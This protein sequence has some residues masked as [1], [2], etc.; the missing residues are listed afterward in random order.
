[1][2]QVNPE[3]LY[4]LLGG[5]LCLFGFAL[6]WGGLRVVGMFMGGS[7]AAIMTIIIAY[8][9]HMERMLALAV[10][11]LATLG[12]M[13]VGWRLLKGA[14][15]FLVF[16]IGAGLG[17]LIVKTIL[18]PYYGGL[19]EV[20]WVPLAAIVIGGILGLLLYRYVV[21]LVTAAVGSYL[22]YLAVDRPWVLFVAFIIGVLVQIGAFHRLGVSRK[23]RTRWS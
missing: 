7:I 9:T 15:G 11:A 16:I 19:W 13:I 3:I 1:V 21:I 12:G 14:H 5:L 2:P 22:L 18:A 17:Y 4:G 6:Y 23:V 10:I 8:S 20:Q